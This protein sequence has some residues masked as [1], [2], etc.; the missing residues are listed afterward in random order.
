MPTLSGKTIFV[1]G[2]SRGIGRAIAAR[3]AREGANVAIV[4]KSVRERERLPGSIHETAREVER[5]GGRALPIRADLRFEEQ[6]EAAVEMTAETFG[7]IDAVVNNASALSLSNTEDTSLKLYDRMFDINARGSWLCTK[8]CL[9]YLDHAENPHVLCISPPLNM[10]P[11]WFENHAPY[12]LSK[13]AMSIWIL[14]WSRELSARGIGCNALWPRTTIATAA[15]RNLLGGEPMVR[16]SRHP[17][18]MAEA[19]HAI[20]V[21][22]GRECSG[23]FFLD[24]DVLRE[25]GVEDFEAYAVRPGEQ[26]QIDL[27]LDEEPPAGRSA[28]S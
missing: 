1:T 27:F 17:E 6:I 26:L 11:R 18:I 15:V 20:L 3:V 25:S 16:R 24:E 12:T 7:G 5:Q 13:Y 19:A 2:A 21:R 22:E 9:P 10:A 23:N 8:L 4:A 28:D 14:G